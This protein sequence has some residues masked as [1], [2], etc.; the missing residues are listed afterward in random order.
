MRFGHLNYKNPVF[1]HYYI[2]LGFFTEFDSSEEQFQFGRGLKPRQSPPPELESWQRSYHDE[3][4]HH[5]KLMTTSLSLLN[6][7]FYHHHGNG[8]GVDGL[9]MKNLIPQTADPVGHSSH[10]LRL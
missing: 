7:G 5:V 10:S 4:D 2:R 1:L 6:S 8:D 3:N 9:L